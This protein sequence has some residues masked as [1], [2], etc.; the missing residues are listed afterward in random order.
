M[1]LNMIKKW[2]V[3]KESIDVNIN[4]EDKPAAMSSHTFLL[5]KISENPDISIETERL[6]LYAL[7]KFA[8]QND[9]D[10]FRK[11]GRMNTVVSFSFK[12]YA[13]RQAGYD[14]EKKHN[15]DKAKKEVKKALNELYRVLIR[16]DTQKHVGAA[17]LLQGY[18]FES[19]G[20]IYINFS[21]PISEFLITGK[22]LWD[23]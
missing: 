20:Q 21:K 19:D 5:G 7:K 22:G 4:I 16:W 15:L 1:N 9:I 18:V 23:D 8:A 10:T 6:L 3:V 17:S 11:L 14:F 12:D 2:F 13:V